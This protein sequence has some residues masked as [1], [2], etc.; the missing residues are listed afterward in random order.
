MWR[1]WLRALRPLPRCSATTSGAADCPTGTRRRSRSSVGRRPGDGRDAAGHDRFPLLG[2]SQGAA[3]AIE[4]AARHPDRVTRPRALRR[5]RAGTGPAG[6][7]TKSGGRQSCSRSW[8]S[9]GGEPT[10]RRSVRCSRR[11]S[12]PVARVRNG[13]SSTSSSAAPR[14]PRTR[15]L[16]RG[17]RTIDVSAAAQR[18]RCPT[19]VVHVRGDLMPP[20]DQGRLL[21]SLM[22]GGR[23]VSLEGSNHILLATNLPGGGSWTRWTSSWGPEQGQRAR[24]PRR[25]R[26]Q[27]DIGTSPLARAYASATTSSN[28]GTPMSTSDSPALTR[29]W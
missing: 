6:P 16:H 8:P 17:L 9:W 11:G 15:P 7:T 29:P 23:F 5:L 24:R 28:A 12:C 2:V 21:A 27:N 18:V 22:P 1:H 10:S 26:Q 4:F 19:L 25:T 14:R 13:T 3:V 20:L